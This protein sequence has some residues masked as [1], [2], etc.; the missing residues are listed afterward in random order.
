MNFKE[1][2]NFD[3][4]NNIQLAY[5]IGLDVPKLK[6]LG[7]LTADENAEVRDSGEWQI[8]DNLVALKDED[9]DKMVYTAWWDGEQFIAKVCTVHDPYLAD[10]SRGPAL[11]ENCVT[12]WAD[13]GKLMRKYF[14]KLSEILKTQ[15]KDYQGF[16]SL[17]VK[18]SDH[19]IFYQTIRVGVTFDFACCFSTLYDVEIADIEEEIAIDTPTLDKYSGSMRIYIYPWHSLNNKKMLEGLDYGVKMYEGTDS[20]IITGTGPQIFSTW[21]NIREKAEGLPRY[22]VFRCD[23]DKLA[24][25]T[26]KKMKSQ[27]FL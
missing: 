21:N 7:V 4:K 1:K 22:M 19:G 24:R 3:I 15:H 20:F 6:V 8:V 2:I 18:V 16:V 25:Q 17:D 5:E 27:R 10:G 11:E 26:F 12:M 14:G 23:G 13:P 9:G